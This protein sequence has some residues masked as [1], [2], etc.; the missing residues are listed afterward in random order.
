M[1]AIRLASSQH[2]PAA[3]H[4]LQTEKQS[5]LCRRARQFAIPN[6]HM[7]NASPRSANVRTI[8]LLHYLVQVS[9]A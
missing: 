8:S 7:F 1:R 5:G 6:I 2:F 9:R 4:A 3:C